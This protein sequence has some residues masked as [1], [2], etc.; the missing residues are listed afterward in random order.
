MLP[1][2][3]LANLCD[4]PVHPLAAIRVFMIDGARDLKSQSCVKF[5]LADTRSDGRLLTLKAIR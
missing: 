3:G 5:F 4:P 1:F 2:A